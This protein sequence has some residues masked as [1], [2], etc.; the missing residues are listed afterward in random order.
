[1]ELVGHLLCPD[2]SL[3]FKAVGS[4]R[5]IAQTERVINYLEQ[6]DIQAADSEAAVH[7][8]SVKVSSELATVTTT[9]VTNSV[10]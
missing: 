7:T 2:V 5:G 10:S 3:A 4:S 9:L 8:E 6:S 1:L